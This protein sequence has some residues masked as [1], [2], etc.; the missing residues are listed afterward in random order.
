MT[1]SSDDPAPWSG[2]EDEKRPVTYRKPG[3]FIRTRARLPAGRRFPDVFP[4]NA[5]TAQRVQRIVL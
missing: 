1:E 3:M 5:E 2:K 4:G